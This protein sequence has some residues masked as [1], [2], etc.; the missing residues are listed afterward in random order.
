[1][2]FGNFTRAN[3][4]GALLKMQRERANLSQ[5][6]LAHLFG[7]RA[8]NGQFFSNV[9]RGKCG[10]PPKHIPALAKLFNLPEE[11][12]KDAVVRDTLERLE[13]EIE[14]GRK[15]AEGGQYEPRS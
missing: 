10:L 13:R 1:M 5:R 6:E 7:Y 15:I 8:A 11:I 4:A 3:H 2:S 12:I 9:E 14:E